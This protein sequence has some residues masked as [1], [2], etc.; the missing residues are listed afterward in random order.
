MT[1]EEIKEKLEEL[2]AAEKRQAERAEHISASLDAVKKRLNKEQEKLSA[3]RTEIQRYEGY[4][5]RKLTEAYG[6]DTY[7]KLR[8]FLSENAAKE[9]KEKGQIS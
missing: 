8:A 2:R 1:E 6:F 3:V 5:L 9:K 4:L 7:D